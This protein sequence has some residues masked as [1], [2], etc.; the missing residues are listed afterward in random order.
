L[1]ILNVNKSNGGAMNTTRKGDEFENRVFKLLRDEFAKGEVF[2]PHNL[3]LY[4]KKE[5][6]SK[7]RE[8]NIIVDLSVEIRR[9]GEKKW[10]LLIVCECKNYS[11]PIGI[12]D[13]EEFSSKLK[14]IGANKGIIISNNSMQKGALK[15]AQNYKM[16]FIRVMGNSKMK[17]E[18]TRIMRYSSDFTERA[19][20]HKSIEDALINED[21]NNARSRM[22]CW[23]NNYTN[24]L[25]TFLFNILPEDARGT[26][27]NYVSIREPVQKQTSPIVSFLSCEEI[28]K[29]CLY[30]HEAI[31]YRVGA[32]ALK[33]VLDLLKR[34]DGVLVEYEDDLGERSD[35]KRILG[36]IEFNPPKI[37][38]SK[39]ACGNL[40]RERFTLA[41]EL[42]H[43]LLGHGKYLVREKYDVDDESDFIVN[44]EIKRLEWQANYFA[45]SLLLPEKN[46]NK[47][48]CQ[49]LEEEDIRNRGYGPLY[50][51]RQACNQQDYYKVTNKLVKYFSASRQAVTIRLKEKGFL[52]AGAD[53]FDENKARTKNFLDDFI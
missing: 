37:I 28:Q 22:Y 4:K 32:V 8:D 43:Y 44:V 10:F 53:S 36:A 42:G 2:N 14:Q 26:L 19:N 5:Y 6:Y 33:D 31:N 35:N 46:F 50:V 40:H 12:E 11:R 24:S 25:R 29:E 9:P 49:I 20:N 52:V 48:F 45:A 39:S 23:Y 51:D 13:I 47:Q 18:L 34:D 15:A 21:L 41:H 1:F 3:H 17:W 30:I 38:I 7:I 16:G 27:N